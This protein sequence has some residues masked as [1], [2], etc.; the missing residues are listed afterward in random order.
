MRKD[1]TVLLSFLFAGAVLL[2]PALLRADIATPDAEP[3]TFENRQKLEL[4]VEIAGEPFSASVIPAGS[5][6]VVRYSLWFNERFLHDFGDITPGREADVFQGALQERK[7]FLELWRGEPFTP[8]ASV[9]ERWELP[10]AAIGDVAMTFPETGNY[11][12]VAYLTNEVRD[13]TAYCTRHEVPR[14]FCVEEGYFSYFTPAETQRYFTGNFGDDAGLYDSNPTAFGGLRFTVGEPLGDVSNVLFLPGIKG[15]RLYRSDNGC[16]GPVHSCARKLWEPFGND[17]VRELYLDASGRSVHQDVYVRAGDILSSVVLQD[18]YT[19]LFQDLDEAETTGMF[20]AGWH[21]E[22]AAYDW[23]LSLDDIV[24]RGARY[25]DRIYYSEANGMPYIERLLRDLA[26][27]SAT[28]KVTLVAHSNGGLV[29]KALMQRLGDAETAARIDKVVFVAVP[30]SGAPRALGAALFGHGEAL[31]FDSCS[32]NFIAH[33]ACA[34]I[35]DRPTAREFAE[36]S[37]MTYHLLPS[38]T[39]FESITDREHLLATFTG[40]NTHIREQ[41]RYGISLNTDDE[42]RD[43]VLAKDAGRTKPPASDTAH[44]NVLS[45][46]LMAYGRGVHDR[47]DTWVP[48]PGV[49]VYEIAGWGNDTIAGIEFYEEPRLI[50]NPLPR[51][52][53]TFIEDGDGTVP[54]ASAQMMRPTGTVK[55]YWANLRIADRDHATLFEEYSVRTFVRNIILGRSHELTSL[56]TETEP[57]TP[58]SERRLLFFLHSPLSLAV[59]DR[60]GNYTGTLRDRVPKRDVPRTEYGE[61]GEVKYLT[62]R[63]DTQEMPYTVVLEGLGNGTF[64]LDIQER[65]GNTVVASGTLSEIPTTERTRATLSVSPEGTYSALDVDQDGDGTIDFSL[66]PHLTR[67]HKGGAS[68]DETLPESPTGPGLVPVPPNST[69]NNGTPIGQDQNEPRIRYV[70]QDN[71]GPA[72]EEPNQ[73]VQAVGAEAAPQTGIA[74]V[75]ASTTAIEDRLSPGRELMASAY[76]AAKSLSGTIPFVKLWLLVLILVL[77]LLMLGLR[78]RMRTRESDP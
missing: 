48:P 21:W 51:Y 55:S 23:R 75:P 39:Y 69:S 6:R 63:E 45:E 10:A 78:E 77:I 53:P 70:T 7:L 11:F 20:G 73:V 62:I 19:S 38:R 30:Q 42:L 35:V 24:S 12:L 60:Y 5:S 3:H 9:V 34:M 72:K 74:Y 29:A 36:H 26:A 27:T 4:S 41:A 8:E 47:I 54:V 18:L 40:S 1:T 52:R 17:E 58:T 15:T 66:T 67:I 71:A 33:W 31:P 64:S 76:G 46:T 50:G 32:R 57:Q 65:E 37:P 43:F 56:V 14:E 68:G 2:A 13:E 61:F 44:A 16:G 22:A 25:E 28:G 49:D 59:Y